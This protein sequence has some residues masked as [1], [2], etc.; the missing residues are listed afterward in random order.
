MSVGRTC[1]K[2]IANASSD[3]PGTAEVPRAFSDARTT[4][5]SP[6]LRSSQWA[7][8][9]RS[10]SLLRK[11]RLCTLNSAPRNVLSCGRSEQQAHLGDTRAAPVEFVRFRSR[12]SSAVALGRLWR[13]EIPDRLHRSSMPET[14]QEAKRR[15]HTWH[16]WALAPSLQNS[17]RSRLTWSALIT[18]LP[19][20][21]HRGNMNGF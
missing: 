14:E 19:T 17:A 8:L 18:I 6:C 2:L 3:P 9:G 4:E 1:A 5:D 21:A 7:W 10:V 20:T 16:F 12:F 13:G 11:R 15:R